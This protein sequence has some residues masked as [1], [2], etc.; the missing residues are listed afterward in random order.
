M[1]CRY[2][3]FLPRLGAFALDLIPIL[4][5]ILVVLAVGLAITLGLFKGQATGRL[6]HPVLF[7]FIA[8]LTVILPATLYFAIQESSPKKATWGKRRLGLQVITQKGGRLDFG[9][10]LLRSAIKLLPWQ[11][12]HTCLFHIP[13]WPFA[14]QSFPVWVM[15]GFIVLYLIVAVYLLFLL[16]KPH[17]TPYDWIAGTVVVNKERR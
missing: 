7:D 17:R 1:D 12:A 9:Q 2:A 16:I 13:G 3:G 11:I 8:F 4:G 6:A 5:Y 14:V 15:T 10:A